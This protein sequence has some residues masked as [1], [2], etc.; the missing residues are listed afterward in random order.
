MLVQ[1]CK[2]ADDITFNWYNCKCLKHSISKSWQSITFH[3]K[4]IHI[5]EA[6]EKY[7]HLKDKI[8]LIEN[9]VGS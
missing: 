1:Y 8:Q 9:I 2:K 5:D 6:K 3:H 4:Q 7:P